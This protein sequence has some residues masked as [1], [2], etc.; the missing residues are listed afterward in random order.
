V[1]HAKPDDRKTD[2]AGSA[3]ARIARGVITKP[4]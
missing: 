4:E 2:P 1:I 3:G